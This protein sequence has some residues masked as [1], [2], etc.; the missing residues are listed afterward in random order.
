MDIQSLLPAGG[1]DALASQLGIPPEQARQGAE[2]LLPSILGGFAQKAGG[3]DAPEAAE[4]HEQLDSLGGAD[5][6]DNVTGPEPTDTAR[7]DQLLGHIFG[8]KDVSRQV[9]GQASQSS[10]LDPAL[11]KKMLPIL[12]MLVGGFMAR[13]ASSQGGGA[14]AGGG[15][16][17]GGILGSMLGAAGGT[18]AGGGLGG[19]LGSILGGAR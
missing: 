8:S 16:G 5:L 18:G 9:A 3:A 10:G 7:G 12:A 14:G 17:L 13:R 2:S 6:A 15:G 1:I 4:L 11:L 19:M